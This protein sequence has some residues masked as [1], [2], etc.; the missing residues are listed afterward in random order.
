MLFTIFRTV[1]RQSRL[2][3]LSKHAYLAL[4]QS[5]LAMVLDETQLNPKLD[6]ALLKLLLV[7]FKMEL[8]YLP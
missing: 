5:Q 4:S 1:L 6:Y 8:P 7:L 3:P 2:H